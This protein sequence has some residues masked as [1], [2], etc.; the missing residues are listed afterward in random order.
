MVKAQGQ[1]RSR[2]VWTDVSNSGLPF[3]T[4]GLCVFWLGRGGLKA[5]FCLDLV[6]DS[7]FLLR[8]FF[9]MGKYG[10]YILRKW[11]CFVF[12]LARC[13]FVGR[14]ESCLYLFAGSAQYKG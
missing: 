7:S 4:H 9:L 8:F 3:F 12:L 14:K 2:S 5:P 1:V 13:L 10:S 11:C 6:R